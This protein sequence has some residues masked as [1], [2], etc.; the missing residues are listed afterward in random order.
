MN[1]KEGSNPTVRPQARK[2]PASRQG[3][4]GRNNITT[5]MNPHLLDRLGLGTRTR[6]Q[7]SLSLWPLI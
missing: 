7:T 4:T 2:P 6:R 5:T 1:A 3:V